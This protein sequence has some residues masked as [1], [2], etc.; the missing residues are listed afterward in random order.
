MKIAMAVIFLPTTNWNVWLKCG[1]NENRHAGR[2]TEICI[3]I[4]KFKI[5]FDEEADLSPEDLPD[6]EDD[7]EE[8]ENGNQ[9]DDDEFDNFQL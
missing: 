6:E 2:A 3:K 1:L 4:I 9:D 5:M 7:L 8:F